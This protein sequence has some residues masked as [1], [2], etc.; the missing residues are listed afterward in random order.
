VE[1]DLEAWAGWHPRVMAERMAG[2]GGPWFVAAGW[3]LDLF[4]GEQTRAHEDLEIA[5]PASCFPE[6]AALFPDFVFCVPTGD[7]N[8]T[9]LT[10]GDLSALTDHEPTKS[11][12]TWA[13]ERSTWLWRFDV[14][15]EPHDGDTWICRREESIR[16]P[17]AEIIAHDADGVPYLVP[18]IALLFKAKG[19]REK[20]RADLHGVLPLLAA[21]RK[22]W[23]RD[24]VARVHPGHPW[25]DQL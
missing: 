19:D 1:S 23:L 2:F 7:G 11:H 22:A 4:R 10:D 20:D 21:D 17:Y 16:L 6:V 25:L 12:Q 14:F 5:V 18:E 24:A 9:P 8:L 15:R 3:A 13:R